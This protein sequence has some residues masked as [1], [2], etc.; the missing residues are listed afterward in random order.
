ML[1]V[2]SLLILAVVSSLAL[3]HKMVD[4]HAL[5]LG[6]KISS[7]KYGT[8]QWAQLEGQRCVAKQASAE[9]SEPNKLERDSERAS[10]YLETEEMI[11]DLLLQRLLLSDFLV[12]LLVYQANYLDNI[13]AIWLSPFSIQI[14]NLTLHGIHEQ[15][16]TRVD[17]DPIPYQNQK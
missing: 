11:N 5:V 7:G 15:D 2:A 4:P 13:L 6:D 12:R 10:E 16:G 14:L 1:T 9:F 17:L 8:C 3:Q